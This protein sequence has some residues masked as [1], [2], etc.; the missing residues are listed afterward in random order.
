MFRNYFKIA[1]RNLIKNKVYTLVN[2]FGLAIGM[3]ACFFIFQYVHFE[4]SYDG[5]NKNVANIYRV[6][7]SFG[8]SFSN[9]PPQST[10]HPAV[11]P[12]M[13]AEFPEVVD[14]A[15]V[16]NPAIFFFVSNI[17]Y[18]DTR[19]NV[20]VFNPGKLYVADPSFLTMFSFPFVSGD[21]STALV[22]ANTTV[23]SEKLAKK[24]FGNDN[25]M[26]KTLMLNNQAPLK[27]TGVFKDVPENSHIKF[28]MLVS[29]SSLPANRVEDNWTWPEFYDYVMLAPGA[30]PK[31]VE[32]RFPAF[33]NKHLG[34]VL[35]AYN[36]QTYFHLQPLTDIH[37]RSENLKGPE[38][39]GSEKEIYFL[40]IIGIFVLVIAWINYVNL[41]T[42]KSME[43][44]KEVGLRKVVGALRWQ[45]IGQFIMES[46]LVNLVALILAAVIVLVCFPFFGAFIGKDI[47]Q[48]SASSSLWHASGFWLSLVTIFL[49]GAFLVGAYPALVLSAYKP[50]L[51]LKGKFFQ[52]GKGILLRK[53]LV[54]FQFVLSLLLIAG[55]VTVYRQL[56]FMRNQSLG[57]NLDQVVV[58]KIPPAFDST[59]DYKLKSLQAQLLRNPAIADVAISTEIPGKTVVE[60]NGIRK[61]TEDQT[62]NFMTNILE[63][64]HHFVNTYQM[65]LAAG[66][67]FTF[68][69]TS[70]YRRPK[71]KVI[72]NE[73]VVKGLGFKSNEAALR[74]NIIIPYG[75]EV[76]AE[77]IGVLSNY[78]QRSLRENYDPMIYLYPSGTNWAYLS[79]HIRAGNVTNS[80][81][82]IENTYKSTFAGAP[83]EYFFLN[84]FFDRQYQSDQRFGKVFGLFTILTIIVACLGLL[85]LASFI[86]RLRVREIGIRKVLGA[87]IYSILVLFSKDFVILVGIAAVIALPVTYFLVH[88]WLSNYA[89]HISLDAFIF[90]LP[91]L[92]LLFISLITIGLQSLKAALA[93]P[94][95]SIKAE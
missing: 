30:D 17:S 86:V 77:I 43:R 48:G 75:I 31:K 91:P 39:N 53:V 21:P 13:K 89:F 55:T 24:Y 47:S 79:V 11:G 64:D 80:L 56:F 46:V 41:S 90:I 76:H 60:R 32:A 78:H 66:R 22:A 27:V 19:G 1:Y 52:S 72:V 68:Q 8:G 5:F 44:A 23:I 63:V 88:L 35:K 83:F 12:A 62:H 45:L 26:G 36:F 93:N 61:E 34:A 49:T 84:E 71:T 81:S 87:S 94:V 54:S 92:I 28:D 15:R 50:V 18:T 67:D 73:E 59:F 2:I 25:P 6:N 42:A 37:L 74:Q 4:S 9:M 38:D 14:Y 70:D 3:A 51:V 65:R 16:V 7:I 29:F 33:I 20:V 69:D 10:N 58:M 82:T 85:G 95:K 57:Y 40:T